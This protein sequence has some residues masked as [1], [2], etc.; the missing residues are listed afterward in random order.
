MAK[1]LLTKTLYTGFDLLN[2][3][4]LHHYYKEAEKHNN[5]SVSRTE[6]LRKY[7]EK[8]NFNPVLEDNPL[9][10]K[11]EV[12]E[13]T[14]ALKQ[15]DIYSWAYTGGSF[16]E[17]LRMPYSKKR[18]LIRTGTFRYFN[19]IGG[20]ELGSSFAIIRAKDKPK[21]K[22][23]LRNETVII[24]ADVSESKLESDIQ[25]LKHNNVKTLMGYPT[26]MYELAILLNK[27][28]ELKKGLKIKSLI[29]TSE[30]LEDEK[31]GFVHEV[32]GCNFIDRYSNEEVGL[33][34]QQSKFREDYRVNQYGVYVEVVDPATLK[35]VKT[36]EEGK[37]VV[38]DTSNDLVPMVRYDTGD[39]AI[40]GLYKD[41]H[42]QTIKKV[43]GRTSDKLSDTS[44]G[45]ISSLALGPLIYKPLANAGLNIQFQ[46]SQLEEKKYVLKLKINEKE[47]S[48]DLKDL[49]YNNLMERLGSDADLS[50]NFVDDIPPLPSG[51]RPVYLNLLK[52]KK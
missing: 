29:S 5:S 45:P 46:L 22:K 36:G 24:P 13:Y 49:I 20:Y 35:P 26:V 11:K 41:G 40:A 25:M 44:G 38:S 42:L 30:M 6:E 33:I 12:I 48:T 18:D 3:R 9:M 37:V 47:F 19:E 31:R 39:L 7:L 21:F 51:K 17:P 16:G 1:K 34:G 2:K 27:K 43:I 52:T 8:W 15:E 28:P 32:F 14:K 4:Q 23:F 10:G 50:V